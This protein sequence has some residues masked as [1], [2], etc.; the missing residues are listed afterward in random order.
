M[1][2]KKCVDMNCR[3]VIPGNLE[4]CKIQSLKLIF[5]VA[6]SGIRY[7]YLPHLIA[8]KD[9]SHSVQCLKFYILRFFYQRK[10]FIFFPIFFLKF[11]QKKGKKEKE[12]KVK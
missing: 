4:Y 12:K 5:N 6:Q 9:R 11:L 8:T 7:K 2:S 3:G 1:L 10:C